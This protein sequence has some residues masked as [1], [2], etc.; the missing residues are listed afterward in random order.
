MKTH[1]LLLQDAAHMS[2]PVLNQDAG[3]ESSLSIGTRPL[4]DIMD[5]FPYS[6]SAAGGKQAADPQLVWTFD[7]SSVN[8][9]TV[10]QSGDGN[11]TFIPMPLI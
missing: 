10:A 6:R 7:V 2:V 11:G 5:R 8:V 1:R 3:N 9:K 4:K